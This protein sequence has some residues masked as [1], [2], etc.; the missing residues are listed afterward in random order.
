MAWPL[1]KLLQSDTGR[2]INARYFLPFKRRCFGLPV[3]RDWKFRTGK[4]NTKKNDRAENA[5][6]SENAGPNCRSG[7]CRTGNAEQKPIS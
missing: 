7:Q 4:Y 2:L 6:L 1:K 5:G 3:S